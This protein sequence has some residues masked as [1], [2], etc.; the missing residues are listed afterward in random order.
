MDDTLIA[1]GEDVSNPNLRYVLAARVFS[2]AIQ[3]KWKNNRLKEGT[4]LLAIMQEYNITD[5]ASYAEAV[6]AAVNG[7][8]YALRSR[9]RENQELSTELSACIGYYGDWKKYQKH[10]RAWEKLPGIKR[11]GFEQ[12]DEHELR[13]YRQAVT[14]LRRRQTDEENIGYKAWKKALEQLNKER[15]MLDYQMQEQ[16]EEIRR[17][18]SA[19]RE[20]VR[21]NKQKSPDHYEQ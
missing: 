21:E 2:S 8:F 6:K 18:E 20:F 9:K 13:Q 4:G 15:F 3:P 10:Y 1:R 5:A 17:V 12:K 14:A 16:K 7:K 19:K 11:N